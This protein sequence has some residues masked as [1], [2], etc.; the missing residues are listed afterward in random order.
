MDKRLDSLLRNWLWVAHDYGER[1]MLDQS[2]PDDYI[3][4]VPEAPMGNLLGYQYDENPQ[5]NQGGILRYI[6]CHGLGRWLLL[7]FHQLYADLDGTPGP[8]VL[9]ASA[10][11]WSPG[12]PQFHI[13]A[14]PNAILSQPKAEREAIEKHSLFRPNSV[15]DD[16][17]SFIRIS[18]VQGK[19]REDNIRR[20]MRYLGAPQGSGPSLLEREL[21]YWQEQGMRRKVLVVV[22][23]YQE[24]RLAAHALLEMPGWRDRVVSLHPDDDDALDTWLLPRADV[25]NLSARKADVLIA[26][27]LAIQRGFNILD[28]AGAALL[29]TA[30]F[31]TRPIPVPSDLGQHVTGVN[32]W[33]VRRLTAAGGKLPASGYGSLSGAVREMRQSAYREWRRRIEAGQFGIAGMDKDLQ[34][35]LMWDQFVAVWQTVGRLVRRGRPARVFFVD[36]AFHPQAGV[37]MLHQ[38]VQMLREYLG[39][40]SNRSE[41]EREL[42]ETLYGPAY[43]ALSKAIQ[44]PT[45]LRPDVPTTVA[46]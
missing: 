11:S 15:P 3:N 29:G 27:L 23:S 33:A 40:S 17:G 39:E 21:Q 16:T 5:R 35:E 7:N 14:P 6:Q 38:W 13:T 46:G 4:L 42:A 26:P 34:Q 12:S 37:S 45:I 1:A 22:G 19:K 8:H 10:T 24:A 2:P 18:G 32:S 36:A 41:V 28:D 20:L 31:L 43:R 44:P 25:E 30:F 9:L